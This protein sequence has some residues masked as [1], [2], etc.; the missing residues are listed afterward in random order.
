M[1]VKI[2][3]VVCGHFAVQLLVDL[4]IE[5]IREGTEVRVYDVKVI[6]WIF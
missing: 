3:G 4:V 5:L 1:E 6:S 2:S